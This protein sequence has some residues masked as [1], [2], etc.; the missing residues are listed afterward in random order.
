LLTLE[1]IVNIIT[2]VLAFLWPGITVLA[3]VLLIAAWAIVSGS[4][5]IGAAFRLNRDHGR[6]WLVFGGIVSVI[7]GILLIIAPLIGAIVLTWWLGA[8]ALVFG[9]ALLILGFK[10]RSHRHDRPHTAAV[11]GAV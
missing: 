8:Y 2:G 9:V 10:L 3:F 5:M 6:G 4:L 11:Q 1:G 7:Y